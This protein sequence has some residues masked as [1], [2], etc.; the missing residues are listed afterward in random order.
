ME[1]RWTYQLQQHPRLF[2]DNNAI[3]P[4]RDY[5]FVIDFTFMFQCKK[6]RTSRGD[7][8]EECVFLSESLKIVSMY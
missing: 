2:N 6:G 7:V 5:K 3:P 8:T 4:Q 1:A